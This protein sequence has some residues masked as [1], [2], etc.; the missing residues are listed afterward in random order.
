M[1]ESA[2]VRKRAIIPEKIPSNAKFKE[3][4]REQ[5]ETE[6]KESERIFSPRQKKHVQG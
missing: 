4:L 6:V 2:Q 5:K 3:F 1:S